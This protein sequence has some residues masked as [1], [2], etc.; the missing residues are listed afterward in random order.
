[1]NNKPTIILYNQ[2]ACIDHFYTN[3]PEK[4]SNVEQCDDTPSDHS[5]IIVKIK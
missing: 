4:I 2:K 3:K 1:M 5:L